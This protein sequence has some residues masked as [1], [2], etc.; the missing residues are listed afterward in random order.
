M[1]LFAVELRTVVV[2]AG[3]DETDAYSR[4]DDDRREIKNDEDMDI[5]VL[6]EVTIES[7]PDGWDGMCI[8]YGSDGS[9]RI[10]KM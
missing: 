10:E 7:L 4:A 5:T 6:D 1:K 9:T 3:E 8:P 2:V